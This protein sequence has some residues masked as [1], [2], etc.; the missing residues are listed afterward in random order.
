MQIPPA[1]CPVSLPFPFYY[2][3]RYSNI[4][5][6]DTLAGVRPQRPCG[7]SPGRNRFGSAATVAQQVEGR[8]QSH[9]QGFGFY[10]PGEDRDGDHQE[11]LDLRE[12]LTSSNDAKAATGIKHKHPEVSWEDLEVSGIGGDDNKVRY[13]IWC[14]LRPPSHDLCS[15]DPRIYL[16]R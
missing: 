12:Y 8:R 2:H 5:C 6:L 16:L 3:D 10:R 7:C 4:K 13:F 15:P 14:S 11:T 1:S 9:S